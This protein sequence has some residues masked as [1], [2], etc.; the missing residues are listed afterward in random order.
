MFKN[1]FANSFLSVR[2]ILVIIMLSFGILLGCRAAVGQEAVGSQGRVFLVLFGG[3]S[4]ALGWGYQQYL[5][6]HNDPLA[7]PQAD[8]DFYYT[9]AG[10]GYLP[11]NTLVKLQ[12]GTS[13]KAEKPGGFYPDLKEPVCRFGPE[14]SMGRTIRDRLANTEDKVA[15]VKFAHGGTSLY[16]IADWR[17]DGTAEKREDGKLYRLFQNTVEGAIAA[18]KAEYP[19]REIVVMG[20]GWVQGES[21][22]LENKGAEYAE[23]LTRFIQDIRATYGEQVVF[24]YN[25][26]SPAQYAYSSNLSWVAQW[27]MVAVAQQAVATSM[28]AVF[29]TPTTGDLYSVADATSEGKFHFTTPALLQIGRD[30]GNVIVTNSGQ[31]VLDKDLAGDDYTLRASVDADKSNSESAAMHAVV[32]MNSAQLDYFVAGTQVFKDRDFVLNVPP[33]LLKGLP[34]MRGHIAGTSFSVITGGK[35]Y[36]LTAPLSSVSVSQVESLE[37]YGFRLVPG[38]MMDPLFGDNRGDRVLVYE[39]NVEAGESYTFNKWAVI[40]GAAPS[41]QLPVHGEA[42]PDEHVVLRMSRGEVDRFVVGARIF[43]DRD[44]VLNAPP[45][46]L[47]N[48]PF[49]RAGI[50]SLFFTVIRGGP[51]YVLTPPESSGSI[52]Q[53]KNLESHG[54]QLV[55]GVTMSPLFGTNPG[56]GVLVY[57]KKVKSGETYRFKKWAVLVDAVLKG[58]KQ[59]YQ[60]KKGLDEVLYNGIQLPAEWP[61]TQYVASREPMPVPYLKKIP[62]V[63]PVDV[64]RQLFVD[65]FL[66]ED[67]NL[68]RN[69][70]LPI[71]YHGNPVLTPETGLERAL[72]ANGL[73]I[74]TPKSGGMWWDSQDQLFKLWYE[75]GW[76][77]GI[78]LATSSDGIHWQRPQV[79]G[80]GQRRALNEVTPSGVRPDSW[81]VILDSWTE[82]PDERYKLFVRPPG[83]DFGIGAYC[84]VSSDGVNWSDAVTTGPMGDRSTVFYNPFR[85]KWVFS[86]RSMFTGRSRH[87]WESDAF[88]QGNFWTWDKRDFWKGTG[89]QPGEPVV[90]TSADKLDPVD[91]ELGK[92]PQLYNLDAIAYESLMLGMFQIWLGPDNNK[93]EGAPK[94]TELEFAYSR[95]GFHWDRPDRRAAI[96]AARKEG[97]WDRGYLQST[98]GICA[99]VGDQLWFYYGGFAG[100]DTRPRDGMYT[101]GATGLAYMRRDG[102]ASMDVG[103]ET[104]TLTTRPIQFQGKRLFVN[105]NMQHGRLRAELRDVE[106]KPIAPFT[107]D[108]CLPLRSDSTLKEIRWN[109]VS[110]LSQL[111]GKPVRVHFEMSSGSLYSFWV[112]PDASG[113][114]D[115]YVAAGGPGFTGPTDTVGREQLKAAAVILSSEHPLN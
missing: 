63:I 35:I 12:P 40:V 74:A 49:I 38:V 88:L 58:Q 62:E 34:F 79:S 45:A 66:I 73:A 91:A 90:W 72:D 37:S 76:F 67:T 98:T 1:C 92:T 115:G 103:L 96:P 51:L 19:G 68:T 78:G 75:A 87:Y 9:I 113:R 111:A 114:S 94:I 47:D 69:F 43:R 42:A 36:V 27:E 20:M 33:A 28:D 77:G 15:V 16:D 26:V 30:L 80:N 59:L 86:L 100:D 2:G 3:Q 106:G 22:A 104:G 97:T 110:D 48:L 55:T 101:N 31:A 85:E 64:G 81:N 95:D 82:N 107:L 5:L 53:V 17:P 6:E 41:A 39:K 46:V 57:K 18:L 89:W 52:S 61:P 108:N 60:P 83:G 112:S 11:E 50:D 84:Y 109:A 71:K 14:L 93:T 54:F 24:A 25:Q 7:Q 102:F 4:N 29:M 10:E 65:D 105:A 13:H 99:I 44:F 8:V 70:H 56:D 21:D 32:R 23:H